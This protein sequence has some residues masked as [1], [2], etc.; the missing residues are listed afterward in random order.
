V[1]P[2]SAAIPADTM[3][4]RAADSSLGRHILN[5]ADVAVGDVDVANVAC[6]LMGL[7]W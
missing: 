3:R 6:I 7:E 2:A 5:V 1:N 4:I